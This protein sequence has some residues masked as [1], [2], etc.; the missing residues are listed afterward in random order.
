MAK[1]FK[2]PKCSRTFSMKAH[3]ARHM[4]AIHSKPGSRK[5]GVKK[6]VKRKVTK[7]RARRVTRAVSLSAPT[8]NEG[9]KV[10]ADM[11]TYHA[12]LIE[13]RQSLDGQIGAIVEAMKVMGGT[14]VT[15]R[16]RKPGPK[17]RKTTREGRPGSLRD[18]VTKV[19]RS[20]RAAM[21]PRALSVAVVKA[22]YKT[23]AKNLTKAISNMLPKM[24]TAKKVGHG[25]YR[26]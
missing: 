11:Q 6:R 20:R 21:T 9:A 13:A 17:A 15:R 26:M 25:L 12:G 3:L 1:K 22:G 4:N 2:C 10:F 23:K 19:M 18:V 7:K 16:K 8:G 24:K 5:A 14:T